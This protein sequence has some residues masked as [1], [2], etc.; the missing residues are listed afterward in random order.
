MISSTQRADL[1][2]TRPDLKA[3]S[4]VEDGVRAIEPDGDTDGRA[5]RDALIQEQAESKPRKAI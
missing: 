5:E 2:L 3:D 1:L 4:K